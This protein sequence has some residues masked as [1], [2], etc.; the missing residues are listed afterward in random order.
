MGPVGVWI[1]CICMR[2]CGVMIL[3]W[4]WAVMTVAGDGAAA[5]DCWSSMVPAGAGWAA[6]T[7]TDDD[8]DT[9]GRVVVAV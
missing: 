9:M 5:G 8:W 3:T 1:C 2:P 4:G 7:L 6:E